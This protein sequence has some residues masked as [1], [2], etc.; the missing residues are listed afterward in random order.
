MGAAAGYRG[1]RP[2]RRFARRPMRPGVTPVAARPSDP[3]ER[4]R[5]HFIVAVVLDSIYRVIMHSGFYDL[6]GPGEIR[7]LARR[8]GD[9]QADSE[10][11]A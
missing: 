5:N 10:G 9:Y 6:S 4:T 11:S 1:R 8:N 7:G 2:V 3:V